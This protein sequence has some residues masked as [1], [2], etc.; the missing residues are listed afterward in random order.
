MKDKFDVEKMNIP[1]EVS[2]RTDKYFESNNN[3]KIW[4]ETTFNII[5]D[6]KEAKKHFFSRKELFQLYKDSD[7]YNNMTSNGFKYQRNQRN[8]KNQRG[9]FGLEYINMQF[10]NDGEETEQ[11]ADELDN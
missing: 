5:E 2:R 7:D 1:K 6:K 4:L 3:I 8:G 9:Y 10:L 11:D